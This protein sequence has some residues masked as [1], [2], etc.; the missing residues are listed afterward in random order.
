MARSILPAPMPTRLVRLSLAAELGA[1]FALAAFAHSHWGWSACAALASALSAPL[2]ARFL[3]ASFT[4]AHSWL[5]RSPRAPAHRLGIAGT[6]R[7]LWSEYLALLAHNLAYVPMDPWMLRPDPVPAAGR[8]PVLLVHGYLSTRAYWRPML[9]WLEAR[10]VACIHAPNYR[11]V[12]S[13]IE[14]GAA[15][16]HRAIERACSG[17]E[18]RV[19]LVCHSMGGLV[20]R[21]YLREH[22][23]G[24]IAR[25]VTIASPHHGTALSELG[26]GEHARQMRRSSAF[27]RELAGAEARDP[28]R[29]P[30]TSIYSVHDNLVS[31]QDT[32]RLEWARNVAVAGVGHLGILASEPVFGLVL[33]ELRAGG[34]ASLPN[35]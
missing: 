11:S 7:L 9:R 8:T 22:G 32:S 33:E 30:A 23:E 29:V 6:A 31:P 3:L 34:A 10:G 24:R 20:A 16:L 2:G 35:P 13:S 17:G 14:E 19:I 1:Y 4:L 5:H 28:P 27:L 15:E 18:A 21:R 12:F 26:I 25:L